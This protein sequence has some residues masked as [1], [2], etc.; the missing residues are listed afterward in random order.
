MKLLLTLR[1]WSQLNL[2]YVASK[3]VADSLCSRSDSHLQHLQFFLE[4]ANKVCISFQ[5][6]KTKK[7]RTELIE[8]LIEFHNKPVRLA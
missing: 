6:T 2:S 7:V 1:F 3:L 5:Q 4:K 8:S